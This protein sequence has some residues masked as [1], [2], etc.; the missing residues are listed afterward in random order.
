LVNRP[1]EGKRK[2]HEVVS[3]TLKFKVKAGG[4]SP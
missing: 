1:G 4:C 2:V 3:L